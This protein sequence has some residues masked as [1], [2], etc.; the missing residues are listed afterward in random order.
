MELTDA[1]KECVKE[2]LIAI[3][4]KSLLENDPEEFEGCEIGEAWEAIE[5]Y[6]AGLCGYCEI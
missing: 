3:D 2:Y 4:F 6:V 5:N 1:Q